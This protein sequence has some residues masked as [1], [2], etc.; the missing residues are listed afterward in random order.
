[1]SRALVW[2]RRDLSL[3]DN[4]AW[5]GATSDHTE[6][7]PVYILDPRLLDTAGPYRRQ[8][9]IAS[10]NALASELHAL[11]GLLTIVTGDPVEEV[12]VLA[13]DHR[14]DTVVWN[15]DVTAFAR[16][17]DDATHRALSRL[18]I[19]VE[20][21]WSTLVHPPGNILT[22]ARRVPRIFARFHERWSDFPLPEPARAGDARVLSISGEPLPLL[23][24]PARL[25]PGNAAARARL[26]AFAER[27]DAYDVDRD[28]PDRDATSH[29]SADL[30]FGTISPRDV[31]RIIGRSTPGRR[32]FTRQLAWRDWYAHL[33][34]ERPDLVDHPQ[35]AAYDSIAWNE[36]APALQAWK[37]GRT[38]F[39]IVDAGMRELAAT[40]WMPNRLRL[41]TASFLVKDLL[42][43]WRRGERHFRHLLI[44]GDIPQN[45][46]N[47]QWVAGTGPD[48]APYFRIINPLTQARRFDPDGDYVRRWIPELAALRGASIHAPWEL[49]PLELASAGITLGETYPTP[50]IDHAAARTR[51]LA[52]YAAA[53]NTAAHV[54]PN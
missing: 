20:R 25:P 45:A 9:L 49:P 53:R 3:D 21:T 26:A 48:A 12:V 47:W 35:Q 41:V 32:A 13:R 18:D 51:T 46:G 39:P 17:R 50:I 19:A 7:L 54:L 8:L 33:F 22:A 14:V 36:D 16:S 15:N 29:L 28:R 1:M 34:A 10:A 24:A 11:G 27:V 4:L 31:L 5:A 23:D 6:V 2:F 40:G 38:G 30:R 52:A 44:D 42:I 43:D 37:E